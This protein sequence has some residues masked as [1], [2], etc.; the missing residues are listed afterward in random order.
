MTDY[1]ISAYWHHTFLPPCFS[2][3]WRLQTPTAQGHRGCRVQVWGHRDLL[4]EGCVELYK[5][6]RKKSSAKPW[7]LLS[8]FLK[9]LGWEMNN[10]DNEKLWFRR[11]F[12]EFF[13]TQ[14]TSILQLSIMAIW[15]EGLK[16]RYYLSFYRNGFHQLVFQTDVCNSRQK[17]KWS[18][19]DT[20]ARKGAWQTT[21]LKMYIET[22][23]TLQP[24]MFVFNCLHFKPKNRSNDHISPNSG[25]VFGKQLQTHSN[26][27]GE[28]SF[29]QNKGRRLSC[30]RMSRRS[31]R[32]MQK[33]SCCDQQVFP[34]CWYCPRLAWCNCAVQYILQRPR[35]KPKHSGPGRTS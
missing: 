28:A 19:S 21:C 14:P 8:D 15:S 18:P 32:I 35:S 12:K 16:R 10:N 2:P 22:S 27:T 31:T 30:H 6:T 25:H 29:L 33:A 11:F 20:V 24:C 4:W 26:Q 34:D 5:L 13:S 17:S 23:V 9:C 1:S 3:I 7:L